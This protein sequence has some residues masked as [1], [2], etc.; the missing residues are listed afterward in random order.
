MPARPR[1]DMKISVITA[2]YNARDTIQECIDSVAGQSYPHVE[3]IVMDGGS[4][5]GT[6]EILRANTNEARIT[7]W[8]SQPDAGLYD[9]LNKGIRMAS[10]VVIGALHADDVY[11]DRQVLER[12]ARALAAGH[13]QTCYGDLLYVAAHDT[14]RVIR[15]WIAGAYRPGLFL[16]GWMPPHPTLFV[17]RDVYMRYGLYRTDFR[18]AADYELMLRYFHRCGVSTCYIPRVLVR[19]RTG[20]LSNR[21]LENLV[22]K[23]FEDL[24]AWQVN[25]LPPRVMT[26]LLKNLRKLPQFFR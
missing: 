14:E 15:R 17:R 20:G 9:A 6:V 19:M 16:R 8:I 23:S 4:T 21:S 26:I 25:G 10:G 1:P 5:D 11:A 3:H 24:K 7:R 22:R 12:V 13:A 2:V 18:I